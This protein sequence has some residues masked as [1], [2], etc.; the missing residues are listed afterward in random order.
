MHG[1]GAADFGGFRRIVQSRDQLSILYD[2]GQGQGWIR[3]I[4]ITRCA[5]RVEGRSPLVGRFTR[6]LGWQGAGDRRHNFSPKSNFQGA[7]EN[8]HLVERWERVDSDTLRYTVTIE[9]QPSGPSRGRSH[10]MKK[11]KDEE[12]RIYPEP[13]CHEGNYGMAG[14]LV[15]AREQ[16]RASP[17]AK[18]QTRPPCVSARVEGSP[19]GLPTMATT[20]IR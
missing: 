17:L 18:V 10:D 2:V 14:L 3:S 5:A 6:P 8:L 9:D 11:Q 13:R 19:A 12:N 7:H 15:G 1:G 4:P 20:P 16:E